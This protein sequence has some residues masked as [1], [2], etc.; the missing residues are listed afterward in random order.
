VFTGFVKTKTVS[1]PAK[2]MESGPDGVGA[3]RQPQ[4]ARAP[5]TLHVAPLQVASVA[6]RKKKKK[7]REKNFFAQVGTK[8]TQNGLARRAADPIDSKTQRHKAN[9]GPRNHVFFFRL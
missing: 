6:S 3:P 5:L 8:H 4:I 9:E 1:G 2:V 7:K